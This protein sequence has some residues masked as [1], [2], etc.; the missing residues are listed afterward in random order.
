MI[1]STTRAIGSTMYYQLDTSTCIELLRGRLE[2]AK[3]VLLE[4]P[5]SSFALSTIVVGELLVGVEK[6]PNMAKNRAKV[7]RFIKAFE[8]V[9]FD[10]QAAQTYAALRTALERKGKRIGGNDMLIAACALS[11]GA[12]LVTSNLDEFKRVP[13]LSLETW[14]E[15]EFEG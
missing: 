11:H 5:R 2:L 8:V 15:E 12:T 4:L 10:E 1:R 9:P 6:N 14:A 7:L 13:G 3:Q